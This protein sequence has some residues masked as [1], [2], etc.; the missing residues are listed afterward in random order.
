[1]KQNKEQHEDKQ[2][3]DEHL[4]GDGNDSQGGTGKNDPTGR[5]EYLSKFLKLRQNKSKTR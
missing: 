3:L 4:F 2:T 1:M 5:T